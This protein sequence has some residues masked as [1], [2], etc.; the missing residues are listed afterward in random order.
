[1]NIPYSK[2]KMRSTVVDCSY[3]RVK[4]IVVT[5]TYLELVRTIVNPEAGV[6][7]VSL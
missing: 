5:I 1:M 3:V 7:Q 2:R 4:S 6:A